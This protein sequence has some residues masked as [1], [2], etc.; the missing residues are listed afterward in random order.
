MQSKSDVLEGIQTSLF[1]VTAMKP[2]TIASTATNSMAKK[3]HYAKASAIPS[4]SSNR[5]NLVMQ[6]GNFSNASKRIDLTIQASAG[7]NEF[8]SNSTEHQIEKLVTKP[9]NSSKPSQ[10]L[11]K[12]AQ[13]APSKIDSK[14]A[15]AS[16]K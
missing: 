10:Y 14:L 6:N 3:N 12:E 7:K 15:H 1:T 8:R 11:S 4:R 13:I 16:M 5:M 2:V 9:L